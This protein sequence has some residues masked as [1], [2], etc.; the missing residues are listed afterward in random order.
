MLIRE[1]QLEVNKKHEYWS[2]ILHSQHIVYPLIALSRDA[3]EKRK[4]IH[5]FII[6][7]LKMNCTDIKH[8]IYC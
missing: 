4:Q 1:L 3:E 7:L 6:L 5:N 8:I 2:H